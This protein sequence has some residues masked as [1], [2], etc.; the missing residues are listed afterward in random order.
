MGMN[1]HVY[2]GPLVQIT[3]GGPLGTLGEMSE[4]AYETLKEALW[5]PD[6]DA[7]LYFLPNW[8]SL[9]E[10][11]QNFSETGRDSEDI[12]NPDI[13]S[14]KKWFADN[15]KELTSQFPEGTKYE[16]AWGVVT[17]WM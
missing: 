12:I 17:Y 2:A 13:D 14:D 16:I 10:R 4:F 9:Y 6:C 1:L 7:G 8:N 5:V 11:S 3:P 15:I